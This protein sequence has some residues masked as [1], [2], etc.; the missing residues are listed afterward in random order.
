MDAGRA[1]ASRHDYVRA[2]RLF[3]CA[4]AH[5]PEDE[6]VR[7]AIADAL[8]D[9]GEKRQA[10]EEMV[11]IGTSRLSAGR[12]LPAIE[13]FRV[14]LRLDSASAPAQEG[15]TH[16]LAAAGLT[17]E[18]AESAYAAARLR[19]SN[20]DYEGARRVSEAGL[21]QRAGDP[22][23]LTSLA[24]A[25]QGLGRTPEAI[26]YLDEALTSLS[27]A[28]TDDRRILDVCRRILQL[29][30]E[31]KDC[32]RKISE[33]QAFEATKKKRL[34]RRVA[35][36]AGVL[37]LLGAAVPLFR[38][39]SAS[40]V[41]ERARILLDAKKADDA[42]TLLAA[43][44]EEGLDEDE[45]MTKRGLDNRVAMLLHAPED[46]AK[47]KDFCDKVEK[48][49]TDG[50]D[51]IVKDDRLDLGFAHLVEMLECLSTSEAREVERID[52]K[53]FKKVQSD[54]MRDVQTALG[55]AA[56][57]SQGA[58]TKFTGVRDRFTDD[59]WKREDL[60]VMHQQIEE[61]AVLIERLKPEYWEAVP[62]LVTQLVGRT[63]APKDGSDR[64]IA[65]SA[66]AICEAYKSV[67]RDHDRALARSRRKEL[68]EGYK[69][70]YATGTQAERDGRL[71][72]SLAAYEAFLTQCDDL[73]KAQP[74]TLYAPIVA[75]LFGDAMQLDQR[76]RA[77]RDRIAQ[78][79]KE[80]DDAQKAEAADDIEE[81][82]RIRKHLVHDNADLD[83][84]RRFQ[85]PL[86]IETAPPG[87]SVFLDDGTPAGRD[88]GKTPLV[89]T[90]PVVGGA[91]WEVRLPGYRTFEIMRK[92]A[93]EDASGVERFEPAKIATWT[94]VPAGMTE[95]APTPAP[96]SILTASRSGVVRRLDA[97][98]G[99]EAARFD[100][101]LIDGFAGSA[102]LN[103]SVVFAVAL[104]GKGYVLDATT[105]KPSAHF[106]TGAARA[107]PLVTPRGV[108]VA[109]EG[110]M[111]RLVGNDGKAV[112]TKNVG[113][114]KSDLAL[115]GDRALVVTADAEMA[116][117][118]LATGEIVKRR[119]MKHELLWGPP[120]VHGSRV[121]LGNE[122]GEVVCM[123]ATS[124]GDEWTQHL[125]G[126]VRG[127]VCASD[128]RIVA[129]T[130]NGAIHMLDAETGAVLS[131]TLAGGKIDD[132][133]C[134]L[135]D[136]G[137][138]VVTKK[139]NVTRFD[140]KAQI[141]WKFDA[142]ED[143]S[144]PPRF[145]F[146]TVIIV[147]RKGVVISLEP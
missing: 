40:S 91:K 31:R 114:V 129:C 49:Y 78:I 115:A 1:A 72:E 86:R 83:L 75:E 32:Q 3:Q 79:V 34:M 44:D 131:R 134:D 60:E 138:I 28:A 26:A 42:R 7:L 41:M 55:N 120:T 62:G 119:Q 51:R 46:A 67:C 102:V 89:T 116:L 97:K 80:C 16:A 50:V 123:D 4:S 33:I 38:R 63:K 53:F 23:L 93:R 8:R 145:V 137:F 29:N 141:M 69:L 70:A 76:I 126:P 99:E 143:V 24:N 22:Q 125:D 88:L 11:R 81:A 117:V 82:F 122:G 48:L 59:F 47:C 95:S 92:G 94:S 90:Y 124:L 146:G 17:D 103:G 18:A 104:D 9:A 5:D 108:V 74:E 127:R 139:G 85:M 35:L 111:V 98:T 56:A 107:S 135:P 27:K 14:A 132:G 20:G 128:L 39:E 113:R 66:A 71:E 118:D 110:G 105:L 52:A 64:T 61:S 43:I 25:L 68:K 100:P 10:A 144:A 140:P 109:D 15:L 121:F 13:A 77:R 106:E 96:G 112:W 130:A 12:G 87:A 73:R 65:A 136:G 54:A 142:G 58:A 19:I 36:A 101:G 84:S 2:A 30:P 147:T 45:T 21:A 37:V 6:S 57:S 133:L